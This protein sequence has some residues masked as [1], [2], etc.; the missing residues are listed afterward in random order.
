MIGRHNPDFCYARDDRNYYREQHE[1]V[2]GLY[3]G[4]T[5]MTCLWCGKTLENVDV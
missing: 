5:V 1:P 4:H 3:D 2:A